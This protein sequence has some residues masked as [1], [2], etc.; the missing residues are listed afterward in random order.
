MIS[1]TT[2]PAQRGGVYVPHTANSHVQGR[3]TGH[4]LIAHDRE[5]G[6]GSRDRAAVHVDLSCYVPR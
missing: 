3:Q 5:I 2:L 6:S 4:K 1:C